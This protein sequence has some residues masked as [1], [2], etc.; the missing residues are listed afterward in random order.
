MRSGSIAAPA[1]S[2]VADELTVR[3]TAPDAV[4][5]AQLDQGEWM[6]EGVSDRLAAA[7]EHPVRIR[8]LGREN[9]LTLLRSLQRRVVE[10]RHASM[11]LIR[12]DAGVGK[13]RLVD[14]FLGRRELS[15]PTV[16]RGRCL[17]YGE[18]TTHWALREILWAAVGIRFDDPAA[19]AAARL[20]D[21]VGTVVGVPEA[22]R[23]TAALAIA[24]GIALPDN[25]LERLTPGSVADAIA[26]LGRRSSAASQL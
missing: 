4:V 7:L 12:G 13:S 26:L 8:F 20:R 11:V 10:H 15:S 6:V 17:A 14:E 19:T 2:V 9:E 25:P 5:Y 18:G 16:Y 22:E 23:V 21:R 1:G 24:S 3:A